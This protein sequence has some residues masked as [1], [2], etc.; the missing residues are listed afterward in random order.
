MVQRLEG[1]QVEDHGDHLLIR[2][3]GEPGYWWGNALLLSDSPDA[4]RRRDWE[5]VFTQHLPEARHRA[6]GVDGVSGETDGCEGLVRL[7]CERDL[8]DVMTATAVHEPPHPHPTAVCR[9]LDLTD[10]ADVDAALAVRWANAPSPRPAGYEEFLVRR[11]A[12]MRAVQL[13][14]RGRW[15]G[16]FLDGEMRSGLGLVTDGSGVAR[17]RSVDTRADSRGQGLAG[18]LVHYAATYGF[19]VLR[20]TLLVIVA[21]PGDRA[22]SVYRS[23]GFGTV[24][25][26]VRFQ[27]APA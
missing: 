6:F 8:S 2:S 19:E 7:G 15:F 3:P 26:Q 21:D 23:V 11:M 24:E 27:R 17:Y 22:I 9:L 14:G 10:P 13:A 25:K 16:A 20:A 4:R 12:T 5:D 18:T 1:S